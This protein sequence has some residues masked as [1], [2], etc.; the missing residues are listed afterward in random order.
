MLLTPQG[1]AHMKATSGTLPDFDREVDLLV[2]Q[3][4]AAVA[5]PLCMPQPKEGGGGYSHEM[6]KLNY[7]EMYALGVAWQLKSEPDYAEKLREMLLAYAEL[8][9]TWGYHPL[10][11]SKS[12]GRLF[13]QTLNESVWLVHTSVAYDCVYDYLSARDR[14]YI[15]AN[16]FRPM[17]RFLMDGTP[18]NTANREIFNKL[19]NHGTWATSAVGMIGMV[20]G[21]KELVHKALYGTDG[22]GKNGGFIQQLDYLFSPDGY[23]TEGAYYQRYAIWPFVIF[24]QC[25]DNAYPDFGI[26]AYRDGIILRAVDTL[27]QLAYNGQ[28]FNFNDALEKSYTAQELI[29]AVDIAYKARPASKHLLSVAADYQRKYIVTDAGWAVAKAVADGEA[30]PLVLRSCFL[31][32]GAQGEKGAVAVL[33]SARKDLNSALTLKATSHGM[34]HGHFDKLTFSYYDHN[35]PVV[36]DYGAARFLNIEEK[37]NGHYTRRNNSYAKQT[38]AHNTLVVDGQSHFGGSKDESAK[39][40]PTVYYHKVGSLPEQ[41]VSAYEA[42][43]YPGVHFHRTLA[44][45]EVPFLEY[46][47]IMDVLKVKSDRPHTYDYPIHYNGQMISL[48]VPYEKALTHMSTLGT[49]AGYEHL[50]KEAWAK[51]A[52][53]AVSYTWMTGSKMYSLSMDTGTDSEI[54]ITRLGGQDPDFEL[55]SEPMILLRERGQ[56][57]KVFASCLETHG[58][59]DLQVER[60][61]NLKH[62]CENVELLYDRDGLVAVEYAFVGDHRVLFLLALEDACEQSVHRVALPDKGPYEWTGPFA[63]IYK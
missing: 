8:Y 18:E 58:Q 32:D 59:Y 36:T 25:I 54:Y 22:T 52:E 39:H 45:A 20:M 49:E 57:H 37:Y 3:A 10:G 38:I 53:G 35:H 28:F 15:E 24:A 16:L 42:N 14:E 9:P 17:V 29:Y 6:H 47:L 5:K 11:L 27:L 61:A 19:H 13:W 12:P 7:Y 43:A 34:E 21:D 46:P 31:T 48:S 41:F 2:A 44:Y 33:R 60:A 4:Q 26:F 62:S 50:W 55:R 56:S 63:L 23:Y 30:A 51:G 1:V 40:W